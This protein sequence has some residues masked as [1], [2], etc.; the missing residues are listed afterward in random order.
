MCHE[1]A[2]TGETDLCV[3]VF[4]CTDFVIVE[5]CFSLC[6]C[7]EDCTALGLILQ[8]YAL[9]FSHHLSYKCL[10]LHQCWIT[11]LKYVRLLKECEVD[12]ICDMN[13]IILL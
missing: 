7:A 11:T 1:S 12:I 8:I 6:V 10:F 5:H 2:D 3:F 13:Y 9:F 4:Y